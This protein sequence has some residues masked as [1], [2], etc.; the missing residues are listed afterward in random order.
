MVNNC[1]TDVFELVV[2]QSKVYVVLFSK[3]TVRWVILS[4]LSIEDD[5]FDTTA[6]EKVVQWK[7]FPLYTKPFRR[8]FVWYVKISMISQGGNFVVIWKPQFRLQQQ[9]RD[10]TGCRSLLPEDG[11]LPPEVNV[12]RLQVLSSDWCRLM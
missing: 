1:F 4:R 6:T 9:L 11:D 8:D 2:F 7:N 12:V 3:V 10:W 5:N